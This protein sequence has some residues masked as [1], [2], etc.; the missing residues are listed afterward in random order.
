MA[1]LAG[2]INFVDAAESPPAPAAPPALRI[3]QGDYPRA[4]FFRASEGQAANAA[5]KYE[6]WDAEFSRL[7][8]I[9]G[10]ALDEEVLGREQ[11]NPEFFTRFKQAH[12]EQAVLLHFNGRARDPRFHTEKYFAGHWIYREAT[13]I[14]APVPAETGETTIQ[15]RDA[16][17]FQ[18]NTGRYKNAND[19]IALF[20]VT[21][22]GKHD[23][24][25]CEQVQLLAVD[26]KAG[27]IRVRRG[28]YGTRPLAFPAGARAAAHHVEGPWGRNNHLMWHHN[29][30][31]HCPRDAEGK[32]S[33]D[34]LV[35]DL[36][37]WFGPGGK[38]AAFDGLEF[39]VMY[40]ETHGDT[41]GDGKADD[42]V[43][44]GISQ[45]G[46][47]V[48]AFA[49]QLRTRLGPS[50]IIQADG[51]L[52][53]GG[54]RSQRAVASLNG[55]ES[56]GFPNLNDWAFEDWSG[57]LNRH[58]FWAA[59]AH[60]PSFSYINHK[61][62]EPIPGRPGEHRNPEVPFSSHRLALA[63]AQFTDAAVCFSYLPARDADGK[64]GIWDELRGGALNRAG[65]LGRPLGAAVHVAAGTPDLLAGQDQRQRMQ[66]LAR[67]ISGDVTVT[68]EADGVR[69]RP[70]QATAAQVRFSVRDVQ[71]RERDML[72]VLT[73]H[74]EPRT[75]YPRE[76][77]RFLEFELS[78]GATSLLTPV[79]EH[80]GM[81]RRG[82]PE[83]PVDRESGARLQW[84]AR[85]LIGGRALPAYSIHPPYLGSKGYVYWMRD[86]DV[87]PDTEL[88]FSLGMGERSPERSDG[89]WF[90]VLAAELSGGRVGAFTPLFER[91]TKA[92]EWI[93]CRVPLDRYAGRRVRLKFVAD[94]GPK[95]NATTDQGY[96]GDVKIAPSGYDESAVTAPSQ[97]MTW[98]N[99]RAL[100]ST[101]ACRDI[102][103]PRVNLTFTV[104]GPEPV[105]VSGL[106]AHAHP[107]AMYRLF[108]HGIVL[109]NPS[110]R[111]YAFDLAALAPGHR[112]RRLAGAST[113]DSKT[114]NGAPVEGPLTLEPRDAVF[115]LRVR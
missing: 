111:P 4:F 24:N 100:P 39:D 1:A 14:V 63:A 74:A 26:H 49:G 108:E 31:T 104:E 61:W 47:G 23:W 93:P 22:D 7:M 69:I 20:G 59:A 72:V 92:N 86:V 95:D 78:G 38:L 54:R 51:A 58:T 44:A 87:S 21:A 6:A 85:A 114:N 37:A 75:G 107:D 101:F 79:P 97:S 71:A 11:R 83:E 89:V 88:R 46:I 103:S 109:A 33:A 84:Q 81:A 82:K 2:G 40:H 110:L 60:P 19:D 8:G 28:C 65:W 36:A 77:P 48:M 96:W 53:P 17:D 106:T 13:Q 43:I 18:V 12:P 56:E 98:L 76:M 94:C 68:A 42:G 41:D 10:K 99:D 90:K 62:T 70:T 3:L 27:T 64:T 112:F 25:H 50:R 16:G 66:E 91:S 30:A 29:F 45:Y 105:V 55:I 73:A 67:R 57:G 35:D 113:Q 115:L 32:T 52:G 34:R 15:V 9:M 102:R 80:G 5:T